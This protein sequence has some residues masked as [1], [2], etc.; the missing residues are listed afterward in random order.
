MSGE[1]LTYLAME[2]WRRRC[3]NC[4]I[5]TQCSKVDGVAFGK[6][7][8]GRQVEV[9]HRWALRNLEYHENGAFLVWKNSRAKKRD[10]EFIETFFQP[11]WCENKIKCDKCEH[12]FYCYTN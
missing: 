2:C 11:L 6:G 5:Y 7:G 10:R 1:T 8:D 12:R 3:G 9:S 4:Q